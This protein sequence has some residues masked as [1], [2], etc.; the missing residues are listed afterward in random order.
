MTEQHFSAHPRSRSA[1]SHLGVT[2][3]DKRHDEEFTVVGNHLAQHPDLSLT[4]IGLATHIQSLPTGAL[5]GIKVLAVKFPEGETRIASALRELEEHGYLSRTKERLPSG[6]IVTRTTSYNKPHLHPARAANPAPSRRHEP[7]PD[8][9]EP[10]HPAPTAAPLPI[11][12]APVLHGHRTA[13][14]VLVGLRTR[15]P[16]FHLAEFDVRRLTPA[17]VA[18]LERGVAPD[19][20]QRTLSAG[21]PPEG[22][23][24][25]AG[26][27]A[28]RLT[29]LLPPLLPPPSEPALEAARPDPFQNCDGCDRAFRAH[30]PGR[31]RDC[32]TS[33]SAA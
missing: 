29:A 3:V 33:R 12:T 25:P 11:P 19:D 2:H 6:R 17:V 1:R 15:D 28:H 13:R 24:H 7:A 4:A 22:V 31:C 26:F 21:L 5:V 27:L 10:E 8:L 23:R 9:K 14:N 16:R 20:V 32:R 30:Q 18:W